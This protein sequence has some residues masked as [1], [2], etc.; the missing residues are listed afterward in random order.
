MIWYTI[1]RQDWEDDAEG[2]ASVHSCGLCGV[3]YDINEQPVTDVGLENMGADFHR[4]WLVTDNCE[5][6]ND[7]E[8]ELALG[9]G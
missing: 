7:Y 4:R 5:C 8:A 3:D 1:S 6:H 2:S 9:R